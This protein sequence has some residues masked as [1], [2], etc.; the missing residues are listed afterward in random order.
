MAINTQQLCR[1]EEVGSVRLFYWEA[2]IFMTDWLPL[3]GKGAE[4]FAHEL[5]MNNRQW[6]G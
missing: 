1:E 6:S 3:Y 2:D 5:N 4:V